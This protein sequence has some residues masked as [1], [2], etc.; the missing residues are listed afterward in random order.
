MKQRGLYVAGVGAIAL[1]ALMLT[2]FAI[3]LPAWRIG[4]DRDWRPMRLLA[5][6]QIPSLPRRVWIDTDAACGHGPWHDPDDCLAL[7]ALLRRADI[8]VVGVS[9]VFGNAPL[10]TTDAVTRELLGQIAA[11]GGREVPVHRGC[12][13]TSV[14]CPADHAAGKAL[15]AALAEGPLTIVALGPLTN[16]AAVL[17]V[18]VGQR[19]R[20]HDV[21]LIAV[22]GRRPGHRFHPTEGRSDSAMLFGHGPVFRDLNVV[23]D[24]IAAEAIVAAQVALTLIPYEAG[25]QVMV[26]ED[27]LNRMAARDPPGAWV[28]ARC[29]EWLERWRQAI[30]LNGFYPFDLVAAMYVLAPQRFDCARVRVWMGRDTKL[31]AFERAPALLVSQDPPSAHE[32]PVAS[33]ATY[34][35]GVRGPVSGM[36]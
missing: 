29:R 12:A 15:R 4:H 5:S 19:P 14:A 22:M 27:N 2:T 35:T 17:G 25:R 1:G 11:A 9:T 13:Q 31:T 32:I 18:D 28:A 16:I 20:N 10:E 7:L 23:L 24:P 36:F 26:T 21:H 3:P 30:G 6:D 34:C 33:D 8:Q